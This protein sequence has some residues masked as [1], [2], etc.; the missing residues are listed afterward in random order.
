MKVIEK[1][2]QVGIVN[3]GRVGNVMQFVGV[4]ANHNL[5]RLVKFFKEI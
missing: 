1:V 5:G 4:L 3:S 2:D